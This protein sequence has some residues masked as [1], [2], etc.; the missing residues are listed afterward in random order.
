MDV[1]RFDTLVRAFSTQGSRRRVLGLLGGT[2]LGGLLATGFDHDAEAKKKKKKCKKKCAECKQCKKGKCKPKAN[3]T[4]CSTG[5]CANG[6]CACAED[7]VCE[8]AE[9]CCTEGINCITDV[10]FCGE[11]QQEVCS[12][13]AGDE[14]C[15]GTDGAQCCLAADTCGSFGGCVTDTCSAGNGVC[16]LEWAACGATCNCVTSTGGD[17]LC[18]SLA[19]FE[20]CPDTSQC[21]TDAQCTGDEVCVNVGC[22]C[23]GGTLGVCLPPCAADLQGVARSGGSHRVRE[24]VGPLR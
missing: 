11:D 1:H 7:Q 21:A 14:Y 22:R 4:P 20:G 12:C 10:C 5:T 19:A 6:V 15:E 16:E 2:A 18:A 13:P 23:S 3:G 24:R 17:N 9:T 8:L